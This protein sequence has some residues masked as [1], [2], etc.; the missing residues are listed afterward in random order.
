ML[1][2]MDMTD[3][4]DPQLAFDQ[5]HVE[6]FVASHLVVPGVVAVFDDD[7]PVLVVSAALETRVAVSQAVASAG[8]ALIATEVCVLDDEYV[9]QPYERP[10]ADVA[11]MVFAA[12]DI[13]V[14]KVVVVDDHPEG[15]DI[16]L[17]RPAEGLIRLSTVALA[18][19]GMSTDMFHRY[20]ELAR[21]APALSAALPDVAD[22]CLAVVAEGS[23]SE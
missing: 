5:A 21:T 14:G 22:A 8:G 7:A 12:S 19:I 23:G 18:T 10:Y 17:L 2:T 1:P 6:R 9:A 15:A 3:R 16:E 11:N 4:D 13:A 20:A